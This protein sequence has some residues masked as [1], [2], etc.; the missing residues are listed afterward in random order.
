VDFDDA[1]WRAE[2]DDPAGNDVEVTLDPKTGQ[3]IGK[4]KD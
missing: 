3:V 1:L 2:A 4:E